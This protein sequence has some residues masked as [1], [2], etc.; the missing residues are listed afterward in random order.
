MNEF[1]DVL[2]RITTDIELAVEQ[3]LNECAEDLLNAAQSLAPLDEGTLMGSGSVDPAIKQNDEMEAR[4]GFNTEYALRMH[5]D[6]YNLGPISKQKPSFDGMP[7]GRKYL[8]RPLQKY[9][10]KYIDYIASKVD[11][12]MNSG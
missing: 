5:E 4:V 9:E 8:S 6:I 7:V 10:Q 11:E 3:A 12:V 1:D 2:L